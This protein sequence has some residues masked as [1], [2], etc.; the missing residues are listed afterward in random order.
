MILVSV[1]TLLFS[2]EC[3]YSQENTETKVNPHTDFKAVQ[4]DTN[5]LF[6]PNTREDKLKVGKSTVKN[7]S[8]CLTG[9]GAGEHL[10]WCTPSTLDYTQFSFG[11]SVSRI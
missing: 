8:K 3:L 6:V 9:M 5:I 10:V 4:L 1:R 2:Q 7:I 11:I